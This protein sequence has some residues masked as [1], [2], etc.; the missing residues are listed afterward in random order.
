MATTVHHPHGA[1]YTVLPEVHGLTRFLA[2]VAR[3]LFGS[4]FL[5]AAPGHFSARTIEYAGQHGVP[6]A[7]LLVPLSGLMALIGGLSVVL[8][9]KARAGAWLL[10]LF[11]VPV[12]MRMH[13]FWTI[14]DPVMA[15][16]QQVMFLKNVSIIGGALMIAYFGAG[17]VSFDAR[18]NH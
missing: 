3:A 5:L 17:G 15:E 18:H 16:L 8:G 6:M 9:Y 13:A 2:P 1:G 14:S 10:V 7:G 11:L 4:I 12:T